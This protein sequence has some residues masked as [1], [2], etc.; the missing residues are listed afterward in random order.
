MMLKKNI[1]L[2][3][4][5]YLFFIGHTYGAATSNSDNYSNY[6]KGAKLIKSAKKL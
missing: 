6:D 1:I 2:I 4:I 3:A 5:F